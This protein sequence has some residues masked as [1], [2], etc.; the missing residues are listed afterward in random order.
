MKYNNSGTGSKLGGSMNLGGFKNKPS[1][2]RTIPEGKKI[3]A[4]SNATGD[5][6]REMDPNEG[7]QR[8]NPGNP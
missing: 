7:K 6:G 2:G 4:C 3:T 8:R 5:K 1:A